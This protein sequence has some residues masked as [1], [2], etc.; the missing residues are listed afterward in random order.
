MKMIRLF[1]LLSVGCVAS[2]LTVQAA[3][4]QGFVPTSAL[5]EDQTVKVGATVYAGETTQS[6]VITKTTA[7]AAVLVEDVKGDW[8]S[9]SF[10]STGTTS[11]PAITVEEIPEVP[12]L[13]D[14]EALSL[15]EAVAASAPDVGPLYVYDADPVEEDMKAA[16]VIRPAGATISA[17]YGQAEGEMSRYF[18]GVLKRRRNPFAGTEYRYQLQNTSGDRMAFLNLEEYRSLHNLDHLVNKT[19]RIQGVPVAKKHGAP[20]VIKVVTLQEE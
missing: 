16:T 11:S 18:E 9:V 10:T 7:D 20:V 14:T 2:A 3:L 17:D 5:N 15:A 4:V 1:P 13:I 19:V 8:A 6:A 12:T